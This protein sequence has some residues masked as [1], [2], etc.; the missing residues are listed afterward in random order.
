MYIELRADSSNHTTSA[1]MATAARSCVDSMFIAPGC[2]KT[3]V[4]HAWQDVTAAEHD[5]IM[6]VLSMHTS[7][8]DRRSAPGV[9][10][11]LRARASQAMMMDRCP[12]KVHLRT[13]QGEL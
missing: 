2:R 3:P 11:G 8:L 13:V 12:A 4:H 9:V 6:R 1:Q 7:S 10:A 5:P